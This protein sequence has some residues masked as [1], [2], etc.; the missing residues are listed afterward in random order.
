MNKKMTIVLISIALTV[1]AVFGFYNAQQLKSIQI[2]KSITIRKS[3]EEVFH[4]VQYLNNFPKWS[5]FLAQ[6]PTQKY[7]VTGIDGT[8]GA[9]YHWEGNKGKDIGL[10]EI[11]SITENKSIKM[12]CDIQ[13]PFVAKPTFYYSFKTTKEGILVTQS[14]QLESGL[15]DA[16]FMWLFSVKNKMEKTNEQGLQLLKK[17]L[18]NI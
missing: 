13:K 12:V 4:M 14:F 9:K 18:E 7:K 8:I 10:Q 17:S 2:T 6:D 5:P 16:F 15:T 1:F 11:V 3:K